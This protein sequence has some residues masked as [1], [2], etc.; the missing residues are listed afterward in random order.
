MKPYSNVNSS[1][2]NI[3]GKWNQLI[4]EVDICVITKEKPSARLSV[5]IFIGAS[6]EFSR[7]ISLCKVYFVV[8][9]WF[10]CVSIRFLVMSMWAIFWAPFI[11]LP[12]S[13]LPQYLYTLRSCTIPVLLH[14][15]IYFCHP[16]GVLW[17][18]CHRLDTHATLCNPIFTHATASSLTEWGWGSGLSYVLLFIISHVYISAMLGL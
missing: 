7:K 5:D 6:T 8:T 11:F 16:D 15:P 18:T 12:L 9:V 17:D 4:S 3:K 10:F 13:L 2:Y 14:L 1:I